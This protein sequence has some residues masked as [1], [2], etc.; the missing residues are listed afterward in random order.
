LWRCIQCAVAMFWT[1]TR[2]RGRTPIL[3]DRAGR[4]GSRRLTAA[5]KPRDA[6]PNWR[7][8][9]PPAFARLRR[10]SAGKPS[11]SLTC[12]RCRAVAPKARRRA[13][14]VLQDELRHGKPANQLAPRAV[15]SRNARR[16]RSA[17]A[18]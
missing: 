8:S 12:E 17:A 10:A 18:A 1:T 14:S 7:C 4:A 9:G 13:R 5:R 11:E 16:Y 15:T 6:P 3:A 2:S